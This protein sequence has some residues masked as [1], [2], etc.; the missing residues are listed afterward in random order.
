MQLSAFSTF[1]RDFASLV[2]E[3]GHNERRLLGD[4]QKL[5]AGLI[6]HDD[7][8]PNEF[9]K[10]DP[11]HYQQYLLF[12]DAA[13]RY[14]IVS[15]V[16]E[17]GQKTPI[18]DHTV[19]GMVGVLRG[20]EISRAYRRGPDNSPMVE[21]ETI[22]YARGAVMAFSP[23]T[24]DIHEVSNAIEGVSISIHVYGA[25]IGGVRRH[26]YDR[27]TS[28]SQPFVSGYANDFLPNFWIQPNH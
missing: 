7:W 24:G 1:V 14:S 4:G 12:C 13:E 19:W 28:I 5:L 9:S 3:A 17:A 8:L 10:P 18:H 25:N 20:A 2:Q 22:R 27:T 16:W 21:L 11:R 23:N 6:K 26:V 15:F